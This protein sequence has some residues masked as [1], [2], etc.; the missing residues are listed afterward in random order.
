M[1]TWLNV[2]LQAA[3]LIVMLAGLAS[4]IIPV[5]PGL[6]IIWVA[7][8]GYGIA[9]G[10]DLAGGLIFGAMTVLMIIGSL[11]DNVLMG[12]KA[13]QTG[14]TWW[15]LT[16]ALLAG[17]VGGLLLPPFGGVLA[18][19]VVLFLVEYIRLRDARSALNST[20]AMAIGCGWAFV[21]RVAIGMVMVAAWVFWAFMI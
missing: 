19:L 4:L 21:A 14:A 12:A 15:G 16:L 20:R 9:T 11:V 17:L 5:V 3:V 8:L 2:S 10:F 7:A 18:A 1:P 6:V 13:R